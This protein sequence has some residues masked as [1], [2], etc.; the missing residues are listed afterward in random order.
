[1]QVDE[2]DQNLFGPKAIKVALTHLTMLA[3]TWKDRA[4]HPSS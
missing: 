2:H 3:Q 4:D 1:L